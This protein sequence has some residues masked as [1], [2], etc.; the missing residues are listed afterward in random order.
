MNWTDIIGNVATGGALGLLGN[1]VT[2][3]LSYFQ[4]KQEHQQAMDKAE[5]DRKTLQLQGQLAAAQTAGEMAV[6]REQ[7]DADA[8]TE[9][10]KSE[11]AL[12]SLDSYKWVN[13]I[14]SMN[15]I[16]ITWFLIALVYVIYL[17]TRS[18]ELLQYIVANVVTMCSMTITWWFGQR[19][20]DRS[21]VSFGNRT[22]SASV[23]GKING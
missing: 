8:F 22:A 12:S 17:K 18:P 23:S 20:L 1:A 15:R 14:R 10:Q 4:K 16:L 6:A 21:S 11:T 5:S 13:A 9:S 2:F 3:G 7:G 19:Q